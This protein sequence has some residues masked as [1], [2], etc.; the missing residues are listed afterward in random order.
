MKRFTHRFQVRASLE[1]VAQ[2]HRETET[3][4]LLTPP[5]I[6]VQF[7]RV[8]PFGEGSVADFT[9]WMGPLPVRWQAV[10]S[11]VHPTRGFTDTQAR[12]PF[13]H[14]QHRHTFEPLDSDTTLVVDEVQVIF[15]KGLLAGLVSRLM[16]FGL[17]LLFTYRAWRTRRAIARRVRKS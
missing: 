12:G 14:W 2:F 15:G 16:W 10:H 5:P 9:L 6:F 17:P 4:K 11:A 3:L 1:Q 8:E 7:H 13:L